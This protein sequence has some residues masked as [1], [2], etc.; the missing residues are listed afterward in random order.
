LRVAGEERENLMR[1]VFFSDV[2]LTG[3]NAVTLDGKIVNTDGG[4]NKVAAMAYYPW[5]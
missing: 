5:I 2:Y 1:R 4:G 3:T